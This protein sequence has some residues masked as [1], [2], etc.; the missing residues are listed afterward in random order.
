VLKYQNEVS[1]SKISNISVKLF[2]SLH[3][4]LQIDTNPISRDE[5]CSGW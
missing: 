4:Q 2:H 3:E 5:I 1:K